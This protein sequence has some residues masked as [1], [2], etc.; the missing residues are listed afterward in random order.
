MIDVRKDAI[1]TTK[2]ATKVGLILGALGRQGNPITLDKLEK[3]L[4]E[5]VYKW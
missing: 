1:S 2:Y 5:K 3:S 4:S